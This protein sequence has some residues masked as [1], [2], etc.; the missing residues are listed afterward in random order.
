M[1]EDSAIFW[2]ENLADFRSKDVGDL[3]GPQNYLKVNTFLA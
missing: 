1:N 2:L 3:I